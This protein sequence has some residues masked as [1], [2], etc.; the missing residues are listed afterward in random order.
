MRHAGLIALALVAGS[1]QADVVATFTQRATDVQLKVTGSLDL[2]LLGTSFL[3]GA[4]PSS[5]LLTA[6]GFRAGPSGTTPSITYRV[7]N[8][9]T[10]FA[11][12]V[13]LGTYLSGPNVSFDN[14]AAVDQVRIQS[15]YVSGSS[16]TTLATFAGNLA[17][18]GITS[19]DPVVM[20]IT[21]SGPGAGTQTLTVQFAIAPVPEPQSVA[22]ML[23]GLGAL[24][25]RA[26]RR[27]GSA[28]G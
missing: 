21:G 27:A 25:L 14:N 16:F 24:G 20:H 1:A 15:D 2:T 12:G 3:T 11:S 13:H 4:N 8:Y 9:Y 7:N 5:V 23:L 26:I 10:G 22:L 17:G 28:Q 18:L 6:G 19:L